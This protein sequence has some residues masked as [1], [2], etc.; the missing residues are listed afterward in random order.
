M[1]R[2]GGNCCR[3]VVGAAGGRVR[4]RAAWWHVGY[5]DRG[6]RRRRHRRLIG[7]GRRGSN[8]RGYRELIAGVKAGNGEEEL[9]R[10]EDDEH[11]RWGPVV[12]EEAR[13]KGGPPVSDCAGAVLSGKR[14]VAG[15]SRWADW[16][17]L[18]LASWDESNSYFFS[19]KLFFLFCSYFLF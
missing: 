10:G 18:G 1:A 4:F 2:F 19:F 13:K 15:E 6:E 11:E 17:L 16:V 3:S 7:R 12:S 5:G 14:F 8:G 9:A